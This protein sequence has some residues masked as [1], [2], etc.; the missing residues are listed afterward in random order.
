MA[1]F[2]LIGLQTSMAV[3]FPLSPIDGGTMGTEINKKN[4]QGF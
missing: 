1:N 4:L 3:S 2:P